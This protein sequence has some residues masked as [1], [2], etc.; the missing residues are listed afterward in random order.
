LQALARSGTLEADDVVWA[1]GS[2]SSAVA[3]RLPALAQIFASSGSRPIAYASRRTATGP[4][5]KADLAL[6]GGILANTRAICQITG[7]VA[8]A[9]LILLLNLP[10][11]SV[12][13]RVIWWW[14]ALR[15]PRIGAV[16][17]LLFFV[18]FAGIVAAVVAAAVHGLVRGWIFVGLASLSFVLM[19]VVG[20]YQAGSG[21]GFFFYLIVPYLASAL[22][23]ISYFK[24]RFPG[25]RIG[26]MFQA[27]F[28]GTLACATVIAGIVGMIED[29]GLNGHGLGGEM[30][31]WMVLGLTIGVLGTA[32][33][34]AAGVLGLVGLKPK[35]S[36]AVNWTAVGCAGASIVL[37]FFAIMI[38]AGGLASE[39]TDKSGIFIFTCF[40]VITVFGMFLAL[41]AVGLAEIFVSSHVR[42]ITNEQN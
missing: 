14:D 34:I 40:R 19:L 6:A 21:G 37:P 29:S 3:A 7:I 12:Q 17:I 24:G 20:L 22:V 30:P 39:F 28:G 36:P 42:A 27:I 23:G 1:D 4:V 16:G 13:D 5:S 33:G 35:Y 18:L 38:V 10:I 32:A 8:G 31:G 11:A 26:T 2:D 41:L 25:A 9:A 15:Q